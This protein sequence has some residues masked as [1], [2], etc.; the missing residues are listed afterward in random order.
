MQTFELIFNK[1]EALFI[2]R[3]PD[4]ICKINEAHNDGIILKDFE[5]KNLL[6]NCNKVPSFLFCMEEANY[7]EKDRILENTVFEVS[8]KLT[9]QPHNE[10]KLIEF[11]R[12]IEA[13]SIMLNEAETDTWSSIT[14]DKYKQNTIYLRI[15]A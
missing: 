4:Y 7:E 5:N 9:L 12:Y 14:L 2:E 6:D 13:I 8:F 1:L 15:V 3:F 10:N 11:W